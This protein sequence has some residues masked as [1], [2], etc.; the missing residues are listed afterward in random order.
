MGA[1]GDLAPLAHLSLP[2]IGKGEVY[3]NNER[4]SG[5][6]ILKKFNWDKINLKSK[7]GL[8]LLNGTQ[9]MSAYGVHIILKSFKL[10]YLADLIGTLS[11]EAFDG[12]I[13]P[14]NELIHFIRPHNGQIKTA[15]LIKEFL[16]DSELINMA[17]EHVQD[18][19]SF[20]CM[21]QVH[22]ASKDALEYFFAIF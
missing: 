12:R 19:Y 2:L 4:Y 21:P 22:G 17:K 16:E 10:S 14:F 11:L 15:Q 5:A 13:D 6:D 8:A 3:F 7:E 18:P 9:F 1:S 20:R